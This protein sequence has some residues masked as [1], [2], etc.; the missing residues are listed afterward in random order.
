MQK[1]HEIISTISVTH[2]QKYMTYPLRVPEQDAK[3]TYNHEHHSSHQHAKV[4]NS[5]PMSTRAGGKLSMKPFLLPTCWNVQLT[6]YECQ[7]RKNHEHETMSSIPLTNMPECTTHP[8]WVPEQDEPWAW[9]HEHHVSHQK[10]RMYSSP[11]ISAQAGC[12][13]CM[14]PW[15]QFQS[16]TCKNAQLTNYKCQS[17][18]QI[19]H[20]IISTI[21]VT[22][23]PEYTTHQL[24][25]PEQ[26][27]ES[28]ATFKWPKCWI[29]NSPP[30]NAKAGY[31]TDM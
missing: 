4:H 15:A 26:D 21:P 17:R 24:W 2:M 30:I 20:E 14:K 23:M 9:N 11:A 16:S 1:W 31:R 29:Y 19:G 3:Q 7:S 25:V 5:P 8:L 10:T 12:R 22:N 27:A 18:M 28:S 13:M 6:L